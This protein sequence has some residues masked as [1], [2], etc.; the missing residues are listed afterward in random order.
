MAMLGALG[1]ALGR[2]RDPPRLLGVAVVALLL[3][4]P[5]LVLSV[6][7]WLSVGATAG[8][9]ILTPVLAPSLKALGPLGL[10]LAVTLG[11]QIGVALPSVLV[12]G[13]LS[14]VGLVANLAAVPIAGFVMLYGLPAC[15]ACGLLPL[16]E[17]V[18][19]LPVGLGVRTVDLIARAA[20]AA[21]PPPPVGIASWSALALIVLVNVARRQRSGAL[22]VTT[23]L[24]Q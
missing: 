18:V 4:D 17:A 2:E 22:D 21:E 10:P 1:F 3:I 14:L 15:L 8:V 13:R 7:F 16:G 11:A 20:A 19:M 12:F 5:L 24:P 6:G 23:K 9:T